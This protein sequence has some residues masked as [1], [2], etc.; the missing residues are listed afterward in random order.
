KDMVLPPREPFLLCNGRQEISRLQHYSN[1]LDQPLYR[2]FRPETSDTYHRSSERVA[3]G[4]LQRVPARI[5]M[6]SRSSPRRN[7]RSSGMKAPLCS[8]RPRMSSGTSP[9]SVTPRLT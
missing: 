6:T 8:G 4:V 3:L 5:P 1:L 2:Q 9:S 7:H